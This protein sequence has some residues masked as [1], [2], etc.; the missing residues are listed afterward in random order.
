MYTQYMDINKLN[1]AKK[2]IGK[3]VD[4]VLNRITFRVNILEVKQRGPFI[5]YKIS[6]VN[7]TGED[8]ITNFT[9]ITKP[10]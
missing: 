7:G 9:K 1:K 3:E 4:Y 10:L 6:P 8:W 5:T 2:M